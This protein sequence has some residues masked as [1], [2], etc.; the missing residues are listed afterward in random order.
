MNILLD[1]HIALRWFNDPSRLTPEARKAIADPANNVLMSAISVWEAEIKA[2]A[3]R[4]EMPVPLV[5][6]A[7]EAGL[8][9]LGVGWAH[10]RRA[11]GLPPFHRDPFD[12]M[13]VAQAIE[14]NLVIATRDPLVRQ[15]SAAVLPA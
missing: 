7:R 2:A 4:L 3:G 6:S 15:Y 1:T 8:E 12:R 11:A 13:L 5:E 9:E 14:E 10:A